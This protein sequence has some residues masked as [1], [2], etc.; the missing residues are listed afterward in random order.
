MKFEDEPARSK[1]AAILHDG[2]FWIPVGALI[3]GLLLLLR[4]ANWSRF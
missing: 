2:H 4:V 3:L 1:S